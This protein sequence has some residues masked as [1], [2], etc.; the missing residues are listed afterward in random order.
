VHYLSHPIVVSP[1]FEFVHVIVERIRENA[2]VA[3]VI[4]P[5]SSLLSFHKFA[6]PFF[7][8][9]EICGAGA[10]VLVPWV[11]FAHAITQKKSTNENISTA[12]SASIAVFMSL[13][14]C[15]GPRRGR[16][17]V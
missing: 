14:C 15:C 11:E 3:G 13:S 5:A 4:S 17:L 16:G 2:F 6:G 8:V 9:F 1:C 10:G 12:L 7:A